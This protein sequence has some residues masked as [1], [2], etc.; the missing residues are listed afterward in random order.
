MAK[1]QMDNNQ[2]TVI[3]EIVTK[4]R[5]SHTNLGE[6][7]YEVELVIERLSETVDVVPVI[8]SERLMDTAE[9]YRCERVSITGQ[10]RSY[11]Y[12][13]SGKRHMQLYIFA[14]NIT[15]LE[16]KRTD[17]TTNEIYLDGYVCKEPFYRKTPKGR[18]ITEVLLVVTRE[19]RREDHIPCI[20][21]GRNA[22]YI[23]TLSVGEHIRIT[24]RIQSR[25][26]VKWDKNNEKITKTTYEV[27]INQLW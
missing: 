21:W 5:Y 13:K 17:I 8:I 3:G 12:K 22:R 14:R 27:S 6:K 26:F 25:E 23:N 4:L 2:V 10:L 16:K 1:Y 24:G 11:H 20:C 15:F 7:F 9:D 18:E 19:N